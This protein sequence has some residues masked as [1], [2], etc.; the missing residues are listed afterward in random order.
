MRLEFSP[1]VV[2]SYTQ[3]TYELPT[4]R[5]VGCGFYIFLAGALLTQNGY[6]AT[7]FLHEFVQLNLA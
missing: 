6:S 7:D 1:A 5:A 2:N 4:L 3:V